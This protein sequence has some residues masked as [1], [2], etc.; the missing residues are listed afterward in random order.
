MAKRPLEQ[1]GPFPFSFS[2]FLEV[3]VKWGRINTSS[4]REETINSQYN[5]AMEDYAL[6]TIDKL[7]NQLIIQA[8]AFHIRLSCCLVAELCLT[9]CNPVDCSLPVF[10]VHGTS[11]ARILEECHFLLQRIFP[12]QG[13]NPHLLHC[14][15][16]L[17]H[18]T[19]M[20]LSTFL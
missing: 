20:R 13:L 19:S 2:F 10:S 16:T 7:E 9:L 6:Q 12:I 1:H 17:Y 3:L 11:Q 5:D 18:C 14:R 4:F 8:M 15:W